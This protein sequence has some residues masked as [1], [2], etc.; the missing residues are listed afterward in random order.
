[1]TNWI[2][3][4]FLA[5]LLIATVAKAARNGDLFTSVGLVL[6]SFFLYCMWHLK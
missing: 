5:L 6:Y 3:F 2:L 1:M 4:D